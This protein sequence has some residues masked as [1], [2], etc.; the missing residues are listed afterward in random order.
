MNAQEFLQTL[1]GGAP[2]GWLTVWTMPDKKTAYFSVDDIPAAVSYAESHFDTRDVYYGVGLRDKNLGEHQRGGNGDVTVIPAL[3][4]D[5]DIQSP[6][7]KETALPPAVDAA[8]AFLDSLPL[9]PS[10]IVSSGNGLH[11]YW[12]LGRPL[13]IA[14]VAHR[15]NIAAALRGWQLYIN[16]A[17]RERGWKLDNT[18]DL[19]RVLRLPGGV[20]HKK[21]GSGEQVTVVTENDARYAPTDFAAYIQPAS[22]PDEPNESRPSIE[23]TTAF[24]GTVG[25]GERILEK[26]AFM[27]HCRD[28]AASL[29]EP[30]WY[31]MLGNL[32]LCSDGIALCHEF[33]KAY[34]G[35][36]AAET[37]NKIAHAR[38]AA[39][40][41]TCAYIQQSLG[42]DCGECDAAG[43]SGVRCKAPVALVVITK[44]DTVRELLE[45][46]IDDYTVLFDAEY[47]D[48]LCYAKGNM[49]GDYAKFKMRL[50]GKVN[51]VDLEKCIKVYGE[52]FRKSSDEA[53]ELL[54]DGIDLR[55]AVI[56][57]KW[58][59]TA[60]GGVR[61]AFASKDSEG[62]IIACP[63]PVVVTRRLCNID[64]GKE[65]LE[66][67]FWRDGRWK[68]IVGG[69]TQVYNKTSIIG[70]GDEG[71]HVT[72]GTAGELVNYLSDYET[73]NKNVIPRVSSISRLGWIDDGQFFP[74]SVKEEIMFEEDKGTAALYRSLAEY[75]DYSVWKEMMTNLRKNPVARFITSASFAAPL[76]C[77]IGVRT[78]V[79]HLWH[80][81]ASG[82][83]AALKAAISVW[84]NPLRIMGNGFTTVVGTEQLAGTLRH[85]PFGIDEKQSADERRLSLEH[86]IYVLG[87]GSGK[88]RGAKGGGNAEVAVW[89]NIVMLTGEEPVTRSS[90]LDGIQTRT[91]ELY[92][93]PVEDMD[94]AKDVHIVSE[95]NYGFAGAQFMRCVCSML[96]ENPDFLRREFQRISNK[97]KELGFRNIHADYVSAVALGDY[98]AETLIFGT[99]SDT[100]MREALACGGEVYAL[101]E[102]QMSADVIERAWDFITGWLVSNEHRFSPDA[103]PFYGKT[104]P[105]PGGQYGEYF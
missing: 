59:V 71:L 5:I 40:P 58:Q 73:A 89:H 67:S 16:N 18:S 86:L 33:S 69:R 25:S 81:S 102:S 72:S 56:P 29:P 98:L 99:D 87:Q 11:A 94:F 2:R 9:K 28:D 82:K 34:P 76:L 55:G 54:L 83:S 60:R 12:L 46:D 27:R 52:K 91:F 19:S 61:R 64:D 97:F 70:F 23:G 92:G 78:F 49:P 1:Y 26:C 68:S 104:E 31:A 30:Q 50:K 93:K 14:T 66:L 36:N 7:H 32:S 15:D 51:L 85:L 44:A 38:K 80:M 48:A 42:F 96:R 105:S 22:K 45:A 53:A 43:S 39:K 84:G 57:R 77:K 101:N 4:S 74:Y 20:N 6:A 13:G 3:W 75:G 63:N 35:Y 62:E 65:R 8:L 37:E 41:H 103:S 95:N 90:S 21:G 47:L 24:S 17:A 79:I 10:I 88:I 100:A